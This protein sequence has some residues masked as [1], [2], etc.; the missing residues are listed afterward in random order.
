MQ[1]QVST[2][3]GQTWETFIP[4]PPPIKKTFFRAFILSWVS[5]S[6]Q[7]QAYMSLLREGDI[8][9]LR[10]GHNQAPQIQYLSLLQKLPSFVAK[11][12]ELRSIP[13]ISAMCDS[14]NLLQSVGVSWIG[15]VPEPEHGTPQVEI[16]NIIASVKEA[17]RIVHAAGLKFEICPRWEHNKKNAQD[18]APFADYY[19]IM[20][21]SYQGTTIAD[22]LGW[23]GDISKRIY[24]ANPKLEKVFSELSTERP[25]MPGMSQL[26][27]FKTLEATAINNK[28]VNG[29]SIWFNSN[30]QFTTCKDF[31]S[32]LNNQ[33][34]P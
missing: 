10:V 33:Y 2:T 23:V 25:G 34:R 31:L 20:S 27:T 18:L 8:A 4:P 17:S 3:G 22:Y 1:V 15:Y 5:E 6:I 21:Q 26:E 24:A 29:A 28:L 19:A 7:E 32:W 16:D 9:V 13:E 11:G 14:K 30:T 12:I